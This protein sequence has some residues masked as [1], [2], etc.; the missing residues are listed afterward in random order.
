MLAMAQSRNYNELPVQRVPLFV[1]YYSQPFSV[2]FYVLLLQKGVASHSIYSPKSA[3]NS[4]DG[5]G[6][7]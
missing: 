3:E 4:K 1:P 5:G 2:F 6:G 7:G